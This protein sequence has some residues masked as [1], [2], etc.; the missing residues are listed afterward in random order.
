VNV[1][2]RVGVGD[3]V[4]TVVRSGVA[5]RV[6]VRVELGVGVGVGVE[7]LVDVAVGVAVF[8]GAHN[9]DTVTSFEVVTTPLVVRKLLVLVVQ[10]SVVGSNV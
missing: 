7:V 5:V 4:S 1:A 8:I 2:V 10:N 9:I 6:G 3:K